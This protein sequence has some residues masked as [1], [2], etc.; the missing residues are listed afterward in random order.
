[1]SI[2]D[3]I[4]AKADANGDGRLTKD[5]LNDFEGKLPQ[6]QL[7]H[8][9]QLADQNDDGKIDFRDVQN[10]NLGDTVN[11]LRSGM[12]GLFGGK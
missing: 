7:D 5:D 9:K 12:G 10:F 3:D 6:D 1:M 11:N 2:F 8:L 4:K